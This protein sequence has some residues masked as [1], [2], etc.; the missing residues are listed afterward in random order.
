MLLRS[1][2]RRNR[3]HDIVAEAGIVLV[4][5]LD[6]HFRNGHTIAEQHLFEVA[7]L[8]K[9]NHA[10]ALADAG[11]FGVVKLCGQQLFAK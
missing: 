8:E 2:R 3:L 1:G 11:D 6:I 5:Q 7:V 10:G 4:H 9:L